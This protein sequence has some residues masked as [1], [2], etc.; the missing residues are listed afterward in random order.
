[1]IVVGLWEPGGS[2]AAAGG[3]GCH[4]P[5]E[6]PACALSTGAVHS[7]YMLYMQKQCAWLGDDEAAE[8]SQA[9]YPYKQLTH[10]SHGPVFS[11]PWKSVHTGPWTFVHLGLEAISP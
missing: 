8:Q 6:L 5:G 2:R 3:S 10:K 11:C 1:M 7:G 4:C 9:S